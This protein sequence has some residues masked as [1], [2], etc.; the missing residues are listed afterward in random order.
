MLPLTVQQVHPFERQER[1]AK[2]ETNQC[3]NLE[4]CIDRSRLLDR[5]FS[6]LDRRLASTALS[7]RCRG[8][9]DVK[10]LNFLPPESCLNVYTEVNIHVQPRK[11]ARGSC[12]QRLYVP[13]AITIQCSTIS[14][15]VHD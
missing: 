5:T 10:M 15:R 8:W 7:G 12:I 9:L 4:W 11:G 14:K 6:S 3:G 2:A 13:H 1:S